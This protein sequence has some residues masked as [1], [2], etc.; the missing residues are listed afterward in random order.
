MNAMITEKQVMTM[1]W[2]PKQLKLARL[3][4]EKLGL[5]KTGSEF[6][7]NFEMEDRSTFPFI[8]VALQMRD[9]GV[10]ISIKD[11]VNLMFCVMCWSVEFKP[12]IE[13]I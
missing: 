11:L 6:L 10:G 3:E 2:T 9:S 12:E 1:L 13:E 4:L 8:Y 5:N 7:K